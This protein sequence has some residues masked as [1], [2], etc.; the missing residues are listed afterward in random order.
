MLLRMNPPWGN[1]A[2][3]PV[4]ADQ[5]GLSGAAATEFRNLQQRAEAA[6]KQGDY[7]QMEQCLQAAATLL[8]QVRGP[9]AP[10]TFAARISHNLSLIALDRTDALGEA[11]DILDRSWTALGPGHETT[12]NARHGLAQILN[13]SG[14]P[15]EA[16]QVAAD[17]FAESVTIFGRRSPVALRGQAGHAITLAMVG[18]FAEALD[19]CQEI[20]DALNSFAVPDKSLRTRMIRARMGA[21]MKAG[22]YPELI[23]L[24]TAQAEAIA[25]QYGTGHPSLHV[26]RLVHARVL[27]KVGDPHT[28]LAEARQ[29]ADV[30]TRYNG[31]MH[32]QT[33]VAHSVESS[34][35]RKLGH[36]NE[37]VDAARYSYLHLLERWGRPHPHAISA[38]LIL[39]EA[40]LA[41]GQA[42]EALAGAQSLTDQSVQVF[43]TAHPGWMSARF[44]TA[45]AY[46]ALGDV[47]QA[48]A[49]HTAVL[50]DRVRILGSEHPHTKAS[51]EAVRAQ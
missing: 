4:G 15:L 26:H 28:A 31:P 10:I 8:G 13:L 29:A 50:A 39:A 27:I 33:L 2:R 47:A 21:L 38:G 30:L 41:G 49:L 3:Q 11:R 46:A 34:A 42:N 1:R 7:A 20:E 25:K 12:L 32:S 16:E 18:R 37:A 44:L 45:R 23:G 14:Y 35:L 40:L 43:G 22:R 51:E 17:A 48:Q 5:P 36:V 24:I 19:S 6:A 9:D